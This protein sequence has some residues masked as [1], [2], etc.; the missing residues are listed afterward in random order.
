M[1][2][3]AKGASAA[4]SKTA[5]LAPGST[6]QPKRTIDLKSMVSSQGGHLMSNK[7]CKLPNGSFKHTHKCYE[8]ILVPAPKKQPDSE[9]ELVPVTSLPQWARAVF[10]VQKLNRV[11]S[12]LHPVTFGTDEPVLLCPFQCMRTLLEDQDL[13][14]TLTNLSREGVRTQAA[15]RQEMVDVTVGGSWSGMLPRASTLTSLPVAVSTCGEYVVISTP[16]P[17]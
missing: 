1:D 15:P 3:D 8:E 12:K 2:V 7:N 9:A 13:A 6:V 10:T 11:Q 4:V 14:C 17:S 16:S 5:M